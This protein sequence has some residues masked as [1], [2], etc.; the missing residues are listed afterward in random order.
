MLN[1]ILAIFISTWLASFIHISCEVNLSLGISFAFFFLS[2]FLLS[3]YFKIDD[4]FN[5]HE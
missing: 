3:V 4:K 1:K 5:K 2:V